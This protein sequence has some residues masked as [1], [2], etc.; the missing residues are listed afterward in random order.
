MFYIDEKTR[1]R[2]VDEYSLMLEIKREVKNK[3][4]DMVSTKWM[5]G[6]YY[7]SLRGALTGALSKKLFDTVEGDGTIKNIIKRIDDAEKQI[8]KAIDDEINKRAIDDASK[9]CAKKIHKNI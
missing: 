8:L 2:K 3:K 5:F 7:G 1:I 9:K 6:G 4:T